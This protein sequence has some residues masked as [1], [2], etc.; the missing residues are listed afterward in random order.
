MAAT[1]GAAGGRYGASPKFRK[2]PAARRKGPCLA[3]CDCFALLAVAVPILPLRALKQ[4]VAVA[5]LSSAVL[6]FDLLT[7]FTSE[8]VSCL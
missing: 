6:G 1:A 3:R 4:G 8:L 2:G 7:L 5:R